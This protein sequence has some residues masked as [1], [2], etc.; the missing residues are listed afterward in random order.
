VVF[1]NVWLWLR[2]A[3]GIAIERDVRVGVFLLQ[4]SDVLESV[5]KLNYLHSA[6]VVLKCIK[7][8]GRLI[9]SNLHLQISSLF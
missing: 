6:Y 2:V 1:L 8:H 3:F 4:C 5:N 9:Y 7:I